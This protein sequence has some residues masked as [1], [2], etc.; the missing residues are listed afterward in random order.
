M[1]LLYVYLLVLDFGI[2]IFWYEESFFVCRF[3][4]EVLEHPCS[5]NVEDFFRTGPELM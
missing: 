4:L 5:E 1:E 3:V 2:F